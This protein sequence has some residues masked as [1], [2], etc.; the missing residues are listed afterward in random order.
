LQP[1]DDSRDAVF[2]EDHVEVDE[3]AETLVC[4]PEIGEQLFLWTGAKVSTD[5]TSTITW[6]STI[7]SARKPASMRVP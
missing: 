5:L 3:Q 6:S 2:D 1:I 4:Q 7:R